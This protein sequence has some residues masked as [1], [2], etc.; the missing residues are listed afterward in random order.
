MP[1]SYIG[2]YLDILKH[3]A[4]IKPDKYRM[5]AKA[6]D[7]GLATNFLSWLEIKPTMKN[8]QKLLFVSLI[9]SSFSFIGIDDETKTVT[10]VYGVNDVENI[11][12]QLSLQEDFTFEYIDHSSSKNPIDAKG[13]W[14]INKGVITLN[15]NNADLEFHKKWKTDGDCQCLKAR[16]GMSFYRLCQID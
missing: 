9:I 2:L 15:S 10:G 12:L 13:T 5:S 3:E 1:T 11:T 8:L 14:S 4:R 6:H 7:K 16:K